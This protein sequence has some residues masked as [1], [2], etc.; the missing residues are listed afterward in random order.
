MF[1]FVLNTHLFGQQVTVPTF[2]FMVMVGILL[3]TFYLYYRAP[4]YGLSQVACLDFGMVGGVFGIL[5]ARLYHVLFEN[6]D[7]GYRLPIIQNWFPDAKPWQLST[8]TYY[9][10]DLWRITQ[11]WRGGFVSYGAFIGGALALIIYLRLRKL[12]ILTYADFISAAVPIMI[13]FIRIGCI[14]A[15]CCYGKPTDFFIHF[16]FHNP[17]SDAGSRFP[18]M[19]LHASQLYDMLSG[20][21]WLFYLGWRFPRRAF[22]GE[23]LLSLFIGYSAI[24]FLIEFLRG[25]ADRGLWFGGTL[26]SAQVTGFGIIIVALVCMGIFKKLYPIEKRRMPEGE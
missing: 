12:P 23:I 25:D 26:S 5:G 11:F 13:I 17:A 7:L 9:G 4:K 6:L 21:I 1:P 3:T 10:G 22:H 2:F 15:G 20:F 19:S 16:V 14:G 24:R 18:G 8:L